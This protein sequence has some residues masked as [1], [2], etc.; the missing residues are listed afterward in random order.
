MA[1]STSPGVSPN[2]DAAS[3]RSRT[4]TC[5]TSTCGSTLS[6]VTPSTVSMAA[7]T[8]LGLVAKFVEVR[9]EDAHDDRAARAGEHFLDPLG[10]IGQQVAVQTRIA[11]DDLLHLGD[12]LVVVDILVDADPEFG[13]VRSDDFVGDFGPADVRTE[14][15]HAWTRPA[16]PRWPE[17]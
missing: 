13:E 7:A 14:I 11:I 4:T 1:V 15:A 2:R 10:E 5:G 6:V 9:P 3:D 17:S 8:S 16:F 12:G